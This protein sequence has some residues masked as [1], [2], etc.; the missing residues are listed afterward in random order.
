[1]EKWEL[2][3]KLESILVLLL[4]LLLDAVRFLRDNLMLLNF[5]FNF[6]TLVIAQASLGLIL[7]LLRQVLFMDSWIMSLM[8]SSGQQEQE[9]F[10]T[11]GESWVIIPSNLYSPPEPQAFLHTHSLIT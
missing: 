10:L 9:P 3:R 11:K 6:C 4:L 5:A 2:L 7:F 1:M 8:N